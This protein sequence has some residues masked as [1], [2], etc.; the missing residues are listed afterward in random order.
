MADLLLREGN[1]ASFDEAIASVG[2]SL[3]REMTRDALDSALRRHGYQTVAKTSRI[4]AVEPTTDRQSTPRCKA[5][6]AAL[7][8]VDVTGLCGP[9][10][11][12]Q[13]TKTD[14]KPARGAGDGGWMPDPSGCGCVMNFGS[15]DGLL[16]KFCAAHKRKSKKYLDMPDA[17][18]V[19]GGPKTQATPSAETHGPPIVE[20]PAPPPQ[21]VTSEDNEQLSQLV[22]LVKSRPLDLL[23]AA[24][25][26]NV[27]PSRIR[28]LLV[29]GEREGYRL[30][31]SD[32]RVALPKPYYHSHGIVDFGKVD[33]G[34]KIVGVASD[35]HFGSDACGELEIANFV[36][37]A[38]EL[39]ARYII[40]PGDVLDGSKVECVNEQ[41][42]VGFERQATR[43]LRTMPQLDGLSYVAVTGNH[44]EHFSTDAGFSAGKA[45]ENAF[46]GEG[47]QDWHFVGAGSGLARVE[48]CL[49]RIH[50]P[51]GSGATEAQAA[52]LVRGKIDGA[53][54]DMIQEYMVHGHVRT[55]IANVVLQGHVHRY[56]AIHH[57]HVWGISCPSFQKNGHSVFGRRMKRDASLGGIILRFDVL[58]SGRVDNLSPSWKHIE[59]LAVA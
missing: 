24:D 23:T 15:L 44:D 48:G 13:T 49:F 40:V 2:R 34:R 6:D 20:R 42:Y 18:R 30:K 25:R 33:P 27:P 32:N 59:E 38:Y 7:R 51:H 1:F 11:G 37:H 46:R 57:K 31:M 17:L 47:R 3:G 58:P 9:C 55:P 29:I 21:A 56:V 14:E 53:F 5:C 35:L 8:P 52:G 50:H 28:E 43:C 10:Q 12:D 36:R 26:L 22:K 19:K 16:T 45:L 41:T 54:E 4:G 39:G